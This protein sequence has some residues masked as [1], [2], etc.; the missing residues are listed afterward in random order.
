V[1]AT[2]VSTSAPA[3]A[4]AAKDGLERIVARC[5]LAKD[6]AA[7]PE[8]VPAAFKP[9]HTRVVAAQKTAD[10][11]SAALIYDRSVTEAYAALQASLT[12]AGYTVSRSENEGRDAELF[13]ERDGKPAEVRL[14]AARACAGAS[15]ASVAVGGEPEG[16]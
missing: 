7:T 8:L 1:T 4:P 11:F 5:G 14:S 10:G 13:L 9:A 12:A 15:Q 6:R 16:D 2:S 3:S